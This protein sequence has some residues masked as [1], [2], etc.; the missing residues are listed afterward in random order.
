MFG[1]EFYHHMPPPRQPIFQGNR[2]LFCQSCRTSCEELQILFHFTPLLAVGGILFLLAA[3]ALE[4]LKHRLRLKRDTSN[5]TL[6]IKMVP[7]PLSGH[8]LDSHWPVLLV[9]I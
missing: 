2:V 1:D 5:Q 8:S 6:K 3:V 7:L 9:F 4:V